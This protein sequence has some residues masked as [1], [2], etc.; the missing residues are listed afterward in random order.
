MDF[1]GG[2]TSINGRGDRAAVAQGASPWIEKSSPSRSTSTPVSR[3][4][5]TE[6]RRRREHA[7]EAG[8]CGSG[9]GS[10]R[11]QRRAMEADGRYGEAAMPTVSLFL[12]F[13]CRQH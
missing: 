6:G 5:L 4:G 10:T 2:Q 1:T 9:G 8:G 7:Q 13:A 12:R 11:D 3:I